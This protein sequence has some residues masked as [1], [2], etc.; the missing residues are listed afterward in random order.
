MFHLGV[1]GIYDVNKNNFCRTLLDLR[2]KDLQVLHYINIAVVLINVRTL[3]CE[4]YTEKCLTK[5]GF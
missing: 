4:Q 2:I 5:I 3:Q 1:S